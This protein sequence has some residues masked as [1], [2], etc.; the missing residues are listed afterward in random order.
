MDA[1]HHIRYYQT[2]YREFL[3]GS[4]RWHQDQSE[5]LADFHLRWWKREPD[6]VGNVVKDQNLFYYLYLILTMDFPYACPDTP[7]VL[8]HSFSCWFWIR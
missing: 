1:R 8:G 5:H 6:L 2:D 7:F 4:H 3:F